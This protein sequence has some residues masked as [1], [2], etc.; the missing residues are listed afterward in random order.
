MNKKFVLSNLDTFI[1]AVAG[2]TLILILTQEYGVGISPDSI[3]YTGAARKLITVHQLHNFND[4]PFVDFPA[5]YPM[6]LA[7]IMFITKHDIIAIAPFINAT[8][9]A[10]VIFL[11]GL[12]ID[13]F[14]LPSR[15]LKPLL[16]LLIL[17]S[18]PLLR[19][20]YMLW[21]ETLFILL[22]FIFFIALHK[23]FFTHTYRYLVI[24]ASIAAVTC[25]VRYA[26]ITL[27]G[28]GLFLLMCD[29]KL[30]IGNKIRHMLV[31]GA[32]SATL[33]IANLF[34]NFLVTGTVTGE[35]EK[36]ITPLSDNIY[37][38]GKVLVNWF[39]PLSSNYTLAFIITII[40]FIL[41]IVMFINNLLKL[42][43]F[44]SYENILIAYSLV[45]GGFIILSSTLSRYDQIDNR[46]LSPM[47][48][49]LFLSI[50]SLIVAVTRKLNGKKIASLIC[51]LILMLFVKNQLQ[52]FP[53]L[54]RIWSY[55]DVGWRT[56]SIMKFIKENKRI[57]K[58]NHTIYSNGSS[59]FYFYTGLKAEQVP[60]KNS[61]NEIED[62]YKED[63]IYV[64][65][66]NRDET[67]EDLQLYNIEQN[68][69]LTLIKKFDDGIIYVCDKAPSQ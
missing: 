65:W 41:L 61:S 43:R 57:F 16:L 17:I 32:V 18:F 26:G 58:S 36:S 39:S 51:L 4:S 25:V 52:A 28:T 10:S 30:R 46:L 56:S 31:F 35:R 12:I 44:Y 27:I 22:C 60:N 9:F 40:S 8:L 47:F 62:F 63:N 67:N 14:V 48:I 34:R 55:N 1:A 19:I 50:V 49:S 66:F 13:K 7:T 23:Y 29:P 11:C 42:Q 68:K 45:Y 2:F 54:S 20:Y 3:A 37:Y 5:F 6:F 53:T 59:V 69:H 38:Y 64:V 21:S 15:W 33:L 24:A